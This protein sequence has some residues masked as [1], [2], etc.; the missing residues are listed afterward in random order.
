MPDPVPGHEAH[1]FVM[2]A[3]PRQDG[4]IWSGTVTFTS[5]NTMKA[6]ATDK[7]RT[8]RSMKI[9]S[10]IEVLSEILGSREGVLAVI[11]EMLVSDC[12]FTPEQQKE[13]F[14]EIQ[15]LDEETH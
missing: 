5:G 8:H 10:A 11:S 6:Y 1:Q 7:T 12:N 15:K 9:E 3:P 4:K 13:I 14:K 2:A